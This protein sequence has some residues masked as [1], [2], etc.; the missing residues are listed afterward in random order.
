M[1]AVTKRLDAEVEAWRS[2]SLTG[3]RYPY[4]IIDAHQ[5]RVRREGRVLSTAVLWVIGVSE[6][7]YRGHLGLWTGASESQQSWSAV[8]QDLVERGLSGVRYVVSDEHQGLVQSVRRYFPEAEHQRCTVH[9]LRN[10]R[11]H[12][13]SKAIQGEVRDALRD[14]WAAPDRA[15]AEARLVR[16]VDRVR[17]ALPRRADWLEETF[18]DTLGFFSLPAGEHRRRLKTTASVEHDHAEV[19]RRSRVI[20]IFANETSLIRLLGA[21]AMER[22]EQWLERRYLTFEE[23]HTGENPLAHVA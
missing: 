2:R 15:E 4:L 10:A 9:Y 3:R 23:E 17:P 7:G 22:N 14:C 18:G 19:R 20:R 13:T 6:D 8:M 16:L 12:G 1:S 5:E 21:L 11:S